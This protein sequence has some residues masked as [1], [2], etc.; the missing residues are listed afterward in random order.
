MYLTFLAMITIGIVIFIFYNSM[1]EPVRYVMRDEP[2]HQ[3]CNKYS[4]S[5]GMGSFLLMETEPF[6]MPSVPWENSKKKGKET[7]G[8]KSKDEAKSKVKSNLSEKKEQA[9][10]KGKEY[11]K[12]ANEVIGKINQKLF[13]WLE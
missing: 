5:Y 6:S 7:K 2:S 1:N 12:K 4:E 13:G 9:M 8:D 11:S 10:A 3:Q